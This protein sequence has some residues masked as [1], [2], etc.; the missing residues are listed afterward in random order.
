[1]SR[2]GS[3]WLRCVFRSSISATPAQPFTSQDGRYVL[4]YNGEIYNYIELRRELEQAGWTFQTQT[5]TEV[6]LAAW[7]PGVKDCLNRFVGMFAFIWI[8]KLGAS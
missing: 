2:V 7:M 4:S 6:L 8:D 1:M 3:C 5:D